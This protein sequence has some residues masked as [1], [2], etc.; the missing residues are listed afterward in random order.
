MPGVPP[1][2]VTCGGG[3]SEGVLI[4]RTITD[5]PIALIRLS[6]AKRAIVEPMLA[7]SGGRW[8]RN[9]D[10]RRLEKRRVGTPA[11]LVV[12]NN[13]MVG[14]YRISMD[15]EDSLA[16]AF[17]HPV[18]DA[19]GCAFGW[20]CGCGIGSWLCLVQTAWNVQTIARWIM[21]SPTTMFSISIQTPR[22]GRGH[23]DPEIAGRLASPMFKVEVRNRPGPSMVSAKAWAAL[24]RGCHSLLFPAQG[25]HRF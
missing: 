10:Q 4:H 23:G 19:M 1:T 17:A 21:A 14:T 5:Y 9:G 13:I 2:S 18:N 12:I 7:G 11:H 16:A 25:I 24:P 20:R 3:A 6:K 15:K 22:A 8:P